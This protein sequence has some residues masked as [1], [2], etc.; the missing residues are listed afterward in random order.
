MFDPFQTMMG[1]LI[2]EYNKNL[3]SRIREAFEEH[4]GFPIEQVEDKENF[5]RITVQGSLIESF[6][7]RNETFMYYDHDMRI[8]QERDR[9]TIETRFMKV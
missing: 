6:L 2:S 8:E 5:S 7:Y 4:F 1:H 9:I 3:E